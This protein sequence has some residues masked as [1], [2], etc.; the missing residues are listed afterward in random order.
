MHRSPAPTLGA[1]PAPGPQPARPRGEARLQEGPSPKVSFP[2]PLPLPPPPL[3]QAAWCPGPLIAFWTPA[4]PAAGGAQGLQPRTGQPAAAAQQHAPEATAA[5]GPSTNAH[6]SAAMVQAQQA[7]TQLPCPCQQEHAGLGG[8]LP[9]WQREGIPCQQRPAAKASLIRRQLGSE[10]SEQLQ[11]VAWR[12]ARRAALRCLK[13]QDTGGVL[14]GCMAACCCRCWPAC[15]VRRALS[16]QGGPTAGNARPCHSQPAST[17]SPPRPQRCCPC[18]PRVPPSYQG[19]VR[20][21]LDP[22]QPPAHH[23]AAGRPSQALPLAP[24]C[25]ALHAALCPDRQ[26]AFWHAGEQ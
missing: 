23:L 3:R 12:S 13:S 10:L 7:A 15:A 24:P 2:L 6:S 19:S 9:A 5:G 16:A 18:K 14:H 1:A 22:P 25:T 26:P 17:T 8:V 4:G 11:Q 20:R 21:H